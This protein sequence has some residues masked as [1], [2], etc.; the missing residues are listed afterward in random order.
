ML[1]TNPLNNLLAAVLLSLILGLVLGL[2]SAYA[3]PVKTDNVT[4][5]VIAEHDAATPGKSLWLA[6][7]L[8]I[9]DGWHTYWR[10]PGDSGEATKIK[11]TLPEGMH[12]SEIHWPYPERQ[13][14][15]PVANYGYHGTALHLIEL[16]VD[17]DVA[18]DETFKLQADATWL[19][20]EEECI[21][22]KA[23]LEFDV[24]TAQTTSVNTRNE[25][26]FSQ[27]RNTIPQKIEIESGF[28]YSQSDDGIRFEFA[29]HADLIEAQSIEY[30]PYDWG[31]VQ[32]PARQKL[33]QDPAF[34]LLDTSKGD[35]KFDKTINGVL[36]LE[37]EDGQHKA[38][39][40]ESQPGALTLSGLINSSTASGLP[41]S[42]ALL[43]A[44][45]G[46][47]IL[48]LMPCVFP[49]LFMKALNLVNH[50]NQ[51][52][53]KVRMHG[54]AYTMGVLASFLILAIILLSIK[55]AGQQVGWGFQLQSPLFVSLIAI[56]MF[57]LGLSLSGYI[58]IGTS[59]MGT[60]QQLASQA[61]YSGSFFTGVLAV[62]VATPCTAPFMGPALGFAFTQSS[63][64]AIIVLLALG[65]GLA[66]PYLLITF[67]PALSRYLPK[68]GLWMEHLQQ[69]LAFPMFATVAWLVW[70]VS[71]Q[72]GSNAVFLLLLA[73][74]LVT[75]SIW[76]W[77]SSRNASSRWRLVGSIGTIA[78]LFLVGSIVVFTNNSGSSNTSALSTTSTNSYSGPSYQAF[79][80]SKLEQ[81]REQGLPAFVN[82]TAAWCITCLAN[83]RVALSSPEIKDFFEERNI[84]YFKGDWTNQDKGISKYLAQF[85]RNSVPLY[86]YYPKNSGPPKVLPQILTVSSLIENMNDDTVN[87]STASQTLDQTVISNP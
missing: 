67:V 84:S 1:K 43:F 38:Y 10:N 29:P 87:K 5:S 73:F 78:S 72:A 60:G 61:G 27:A 21:P 66:L 13:Y 7:K 34:V 41:L 36:V 58:K 26:A 70:V 85:G 83:E 22:E 82:M 81:L 55:A 11:W 16:R 19:V 75:F 30:F 47:I 15:G 23:R 12:A 3:N 2:N 6:L 56:V 28:Q 39:E 8:D 48:N 14:V 31:V 46:G 24:K 49:V 76:L 80:E 86:V 35:L 64:V 32:A 74:I 54:V 77:Q 63:F 69:L 59:L 20:C 40:V 17:S 25:A 37:F 33:V 42:S 4:A 51:A 18:N 65:L 50:A 68:P 71:Q 57:V 62:L 45:I 52:P 44:F 9:R 79:D 53:Q